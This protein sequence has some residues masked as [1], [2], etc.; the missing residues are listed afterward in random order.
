MDK[1]ARIWRSRKVML[2]LAVAG[3]VLLAMGYINNA[4]DFADNVEPSLGTRE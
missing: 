2:A 4:F 3:A 1:I